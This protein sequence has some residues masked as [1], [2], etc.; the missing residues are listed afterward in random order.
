MLLISI[1]ILIIYSSLY[2]KAYHFNKDINRIG[3]L[4]LL[5]ILYMLMDILLISINTPLA[6][7]APCGAG[8]YIYIP[9]YNDIY[10]VNIL[11]IY[12]SLIII[13]ISILLLFNSISTIISIKDINTINYYNKNYVIIILYN[14]MGL[15]LFI[16]VNNLIAL[17]LTIE[18]QSYSIYIVTSLYNKSNRALSSGLL[19][20]LI[21]GIA[22]ILL[23]YGCAIIYNIT[24]VLGLDYI[25]ILIQYNYNIYIG[26]ILILIG[27]SIKMGMA[28]IHN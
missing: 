10:S 26:L 20:Y 23:L 18:L 2:N 1:L 13:I 27:L 6:G 4:V 9:I 22:S 7:P 19:Y 16:N 14:I 21:G 5:Y 25:Y 8:N 3:I 12:I 24:G 15:L 17:Y 11:S 28:P